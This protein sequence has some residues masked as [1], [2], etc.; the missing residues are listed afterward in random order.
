MVN[1]FRSRQ[2]ISLYFLLSATAFFSTSKR[3]VVILFFFKMDAMKTEFS[4]SVLF[5]R[6]VYKC[7][8]PSASR[9]DGPGPAQAAWD[10]CYYPS[11][12]RLNMTNRYLLGI[13][14]LITFSQFFQMV[15]FRIVL[16]TW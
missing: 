1:Y 16:N 8:L 3:F 15:Q 13:Y 12:Q 9:Y 4:T 11:K 2:S 5:V 7:L 10:L 6:L 14:P